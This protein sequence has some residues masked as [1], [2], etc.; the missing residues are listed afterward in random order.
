MLT[1]APRRVAHSA[2]P[3][4]RAVSPRRPALP[5]C[6]APPLRPAAYR[7]LVRVPRRAVNS[8]VA[9]LFS[10]LDLRLSSLVPRP[11]VPS[12]LLYRSR[13]RETQRATLP[14]IR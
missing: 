12:I 14:A 10:A 1:A 11:S 2:H 13:D 5:L 8:L 6:P 7:R 4:A 3:R 9:S